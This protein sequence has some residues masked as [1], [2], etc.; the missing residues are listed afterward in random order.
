MKTRFGRFAFAI[1][2]LVLSVCC[3]AGDKDQILFL[4][5]RLQDDT[6]TLVKSDTRPG[7]LKVPVGSRKGEIILELLAS[8]ELVLWSSVIQDLRFRRIEF[9][10]PDHPGALKTKL[11]TS[12]AAEFT[13]RLPFHAAARQVRLQRLEKTV[14]GSRPMTATAALMGTITLPAT[15]GI[16]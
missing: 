14:N 9:P 5:L 10:D 6:V 7:R 4:H 15:Q 1:S 12:H 2:V 3:W 13:V 16:R 8:D 11:I